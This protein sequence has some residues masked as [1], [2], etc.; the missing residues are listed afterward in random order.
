M[1]NDVK[2]LSN[3]AVANIAVL[4]FKN[5]EERY[6]R[7]KCTSEASDR[8]FQSALQLDNEQH[9]EFRLKCHKQLKCEAV[10]RSS[11][12]YVSTD[13]FRWIFKRC[14]DTVEAVPNSNDMIGQDKR[15]AYA[16]RYTPEETKERDRSRR[17]SKPEEYFQQILEEMQKTGSSIRIQAGMDDKGAF[18]GRVIIEL[19]SSMTLRLRTMISFVCPDSRAEVVTDEDN[20]EFGDMPVH[21]I[22]QFMEGL[23][24]ALMQRKQEEKTDN[25]DEGDA[26]ASPSGDTETDTANSSALKKGKTPIEELELSI[27]SYNCLKRA[28]IDSVETLKTLSE[29]EL[30]HIKNL[31]RKSLNEIKHR[32]EDFNMWSEESIQLE[33]F[34]FFSDE[35]ILLETPPSYTEMLNKLVGLEGVKEQVR[36]IT[37]FAK[38]KQ[39]MARVGKSDIPVALNMAFTG[40]PGTAKTTVARIVAGIFNEI[41]LLSTNEIVE[42]GRADLV[43]RYEGQT[44]DKVKSVFSKAKGKLLFIDEAYSLIENWEGSYGDEAIN[45]IVQEMENKRNEMV[46]VFAGYPDKMEDFLTRNPGLKSRVPFHIHFADYSAEEMMDIARMEAENR[47]FEILPKAKD[48]L[49]SICQKA[50]NRSEMG[51][52]RFCRNLVEN[53]I[54]NYASRV[55]GKGEDESTGEFVLIGDDFALPED[56]KEVKKA[57]SM[58]FLA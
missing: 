16:L 19:P 11:Q 18:S 8:F 41:G 15:I 21:C 9:I 51:N 52:G 4:S 17:S 38:M 49:S 35:P 1:S 47:G 55:Y 44:A 3:K 34:D 27:R 31:G 29:E 2:K 57:A 40:N 56:L 26:H 25:H 7:E 10:A 39:D 20:A 28:G 53:A 54:L 12:D 46:V 45:T 23:L 6:E 42:V 36:R 43:A 37:A 33:E 13:D 48:A 22:Q 5:C 32:L 30:L 24:D 14:A 50:S 58:G